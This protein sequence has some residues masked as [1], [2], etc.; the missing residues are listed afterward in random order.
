MRDELLTRSRTLLRDLLSYFFLAIWLQGRL[1]KYCLFLNSSCFVGS[2]LLG[3]Y[4]FEARLLRCT[5][6]LNKSRLFREA[7][8]LGDSGLFRNARLFGDAS[9]FFASGSSVSSLFFCAARLLHPQTFSAQGLLLLRFALSTFLF[10][11]EHAR[12]PL[13]IDALA[14]NALFLRAFLLDSSLL[15]T[16]R[17]LL[18][19]LLAEFFSLRSP[20]R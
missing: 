9:F 7:S 11:C 16:C 18:L 20:L 15:G 12:L 1:S 8:L 6:L 13:A 2:F 19:T 10:G 3:T 5:S 17:E 4:C 14:L